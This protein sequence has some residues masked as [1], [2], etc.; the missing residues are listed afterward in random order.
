MLEEKSLN[1][2]VDFAIEI[3]E[4]VQIYDLLPAYSRAYVTV[5]NLETLTFMCSHHIMFY[6]CT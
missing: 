5:A 3:S 1:H 4:L 6:E 2:V